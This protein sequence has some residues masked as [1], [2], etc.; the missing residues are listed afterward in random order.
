M[1]F[2][3]VNERKGK[4]IPVGPQDHYH[5]LSWKGIG[6]NF[7]SGFDKNQKHIGRKTFLDEAMVQSKKQTSPTRYN[8]DK[9]VTHLNEQRIKV[10]GVE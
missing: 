7:S 5:E 1:S 4:Q 2:F 6:G 10:G 3:A 8:P 9:Y